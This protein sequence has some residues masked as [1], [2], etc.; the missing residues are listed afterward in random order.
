[1]AT[2]EIITVSNPIAGGAGWGGV[3][4][5]EA[6]ALQWAGFFGSDWPNNDDTF[7]QSLRYQR[8][9]RIGTPARDANSIAPSAA[10]YIQLPY[11]DTQALAAG[12][13]GE[14]TLCGLIRGND[15][16]AVLLSTYANTAQ[17]HLR[18][19]LT[20]SGSLVAAADK[21]AETQQSVSLARSPASGAWEYIGATFTAAGITVYRRN[22][23]D[24]DMLTATA[25]LTI[26][27]LEGGGV[28]FR[29]GANANTQ[30]VDG[31]A[32]LASVAVYNK[33]LSAS[34]HAAN[35]AALKEFSAARTSI[36]I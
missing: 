16:N 29:A 11:T 7:D 8:A 3:S 5:P 23:S 14:V 27:S 9:T 34:E 6:N 31:T 20:A 4:W 24:A 21:G 28:A 12:V 33:G 2:Q 32:Q 35:Y 17:S 10:S 15:A 19:Y 18:L 1:M 26:S 36:V 30:G 13:P 25:A 22:A